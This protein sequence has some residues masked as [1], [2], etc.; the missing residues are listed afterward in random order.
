MGVYSEGDQGDIPVTAKNRFESNLLEYNRWVA[1]G[2]GGAVRL[3]GRPYTKFLEI[4][5]ARLHISWKYTAKVCDTCNEHLKV[6]AELNALL[7]K[8]KAQPNVDLRRSIDAKASEL[9]E[10]MIHERQVKAQRANVN[11][12]RDSLTPSERLVVLDSVSTYGLTSKK[13]NFLVALV[14]KRENGELSH[15]FHDFIGDPGVP[16][17]APFTR[18][19]WEALLAGDVFKGVTKLYVTTD[20]GSPFKCYQIL[21]FFSSVCPR[22]NIQVELHFLRLRMAIRFVM[23][24]VGL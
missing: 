13:F 1:T 22:F 3:V 6:A 16:H 2:R 18:W 10:Y 4:L 21:Y 15:E 23:R 12:I 17:D 7:L 5:G 14:F 9:E 19:A 20:C 11:A 24:M 8:Q